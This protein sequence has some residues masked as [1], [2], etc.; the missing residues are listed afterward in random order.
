[1]NE[2]VETR[3]EPD[4]SAFFI[5]KRL[6]FQDFRGIEI[7]YQTSEP[8]NE[9]Q[10]AAVYF[11]TQKIPCPQGVAPELISEVFRQNEDQRINDLSQELDEEEWS[12]MGDNPAA[13]PVVNLVDGIVN[14]ALSEG[15]TDIHAEPG[16]KGMRI[17]FRKDGM[18]LDHLNLPLWVHSALTSRIKILAGINIA[19]KR[20]PQD[21]RIPFVFKNEEVDARVST[22]PTRYGEK[23]VIRLLRKSGSI[24]DVETIGMPDEILDQMKFYFTRPQGMIFVTGPTGSGKSTT[25]FA[26]L[27]HILKRDIN[28]TTVEDPVEYELDG[29]NQVQVN[30][31]AGMTFAGAL[32]SI[33]RQDPDVI[34]VGEIR[35]RETANVAIQAAQT[36]HLVLS[37][38]HTND[39]V[40]AL[41]R[42]RDLGIEPFLIGSSVLCILAQRLV[43]TLCPDC[44]EMRDTSIDLKKV[45]PGLPDAS[46]HAV[47]CDRCTHTGY[48]GRMAVF[49]LLRVTPEIRNLILENRGESEIRKKSGHTGLVANGIRLLQ[50]NLTSAEE[51]AR[52]LL[53]ESGEDDV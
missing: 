24:K 34:L 32:R 3:I 17:R 30:E 6:V 50:K 15:A 23:T 44:Y 36:G 39:A 53:S 33:L 45:I 43:R 28:I 49:E 1:M 13:G 4:H 10:R 37:T 46:P 21:G 38:L 26:G 31:K 18:L 48:R 35:D 25:L 27:R 14:R 16:S 41:T 7:L 20:I 11:Q 29:V 40:S 52:V 51:I 42:L 2:M 5:Q 8:Y 12:H 47:G 22:L 9:F 19:E